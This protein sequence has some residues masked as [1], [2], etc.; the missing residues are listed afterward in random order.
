MGATGLGMQVDKRSKQ[1]YNKKEW[2]IYNTRG[3]LP[4]L[5]VYG[6]VRLD[7]CAETH[8]VLMLERVAFTFKDWLSGICMK[9]VSQADLTRFRNMLLQVVRAMMFL[10]GDRSQLVLSD[11]SSSN[12]GFSSYL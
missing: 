5:V 12:I 10:A 6:L 8:F 9:A 3:P 11:W 4:L 2:S 1:G 7:V